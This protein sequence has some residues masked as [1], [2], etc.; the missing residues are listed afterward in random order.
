MSSSIG[1]VSIGATIVGVSALLL[2]APV[3][4]INVRTLREWVLT[5]A[6]VVSTTPFLLDPSGSEMWRPL[7]EYTDTAGVVHHSYSVLG[8]EPPS[9]YRVGSTLRI[10]FHADS[11]EQAAVAEY[12]ID[13]AM[14]AFG[15][16]VGALL[17]VLAV[18]HWFR[19]RAPTASVPSRMPPLRERAPTASVP[20][21]MPPF[22][23]RF[24][25][26]VLGTFVPFVSV[27]RP[28][29]ATMA[30]TVVAVISWA[31]GLG[32]SRRTF[33][34]GVHRAPPDPLFEV[35]SFATAVHL[36]MLRGLIRPMSIWAIA[37]GCVAVWIG[38]RRL[39]RRGALTI[40]EALGV[41]GIV[42]AVAGLQTAAGHILAWD[43]GARGFPPPWHMITV[44]LVFVASDRLC[45]GTARPVAEA[46]PAPLLDARTRRA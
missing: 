29:S 35:S 31:T 6:R 26:L 30:G 38:V 27:I 17:L 18:R 15:C 14:P 25:S 45:A 23:V 12:A 41:L 5:Q 40:R 3:L 1:R 4:A 22:G 7:I 36:C 21:R 20:S 34:R 10:Y 39:A 44:L 2:S 33:E 42:G 43:S 16:L 37:L 46:M 32:I 13:W 24:L 11:P 8:S 28:G 9:S 19:E